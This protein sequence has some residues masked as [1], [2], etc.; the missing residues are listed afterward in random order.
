M[1]LLISLLL[2]VVLSLQACSRSDQ[3]IPE[4]LSTD[5]ALF[6]VIRRVIPPGTSITDGQDR[7]Q[8]SGFGCVYQ[9]HAP[10][11]GEQ[12]LNYLYC[13][14]DESGWPTFKRVNVAIMMKGV[15][16]GEVRVVSGVMGP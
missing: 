10:W 7:M 6:E 1:P 4:G 9:W 2:S 16:V 14:R 11:N 15:T 13:S 12:N 3:P 8:A 5:A